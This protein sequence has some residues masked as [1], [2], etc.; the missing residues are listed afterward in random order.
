M[1]P[2]QWLYFDEVIPSTMRIDD[3]MMALRNR[4]FKPLTGPALERFLPWNAGR[5]DHRTWA[6]PPPA[7]QTPRK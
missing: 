4:G 2:Y 6:Q 5:E 7:G 3:I 1:S